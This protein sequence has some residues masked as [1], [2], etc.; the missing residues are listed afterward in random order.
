MDSDSKKFFEP[1]PNYSALRELEAENYHKPTKTEIREFLVFWQEIYDFWNQNNSPFES[2][3][4]EEKIKVRKMLI[5]KFGL[6]A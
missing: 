4:L 2:Y 1:T 6:R 3:Y 5:D